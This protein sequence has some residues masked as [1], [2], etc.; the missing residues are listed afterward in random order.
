MIPVPCLG[1]NNELQIVDI[2]NLD[3]S[4]LL[5][6]YQLSHPIGL[7]K[8]GN[9]LFICDDRDGLKI[10]DAADVS[11]LKLLSQLKDQEVYDVIAQNGHAIVLG[12]KRFVSI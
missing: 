11:N 7:S 5:Q 2:H 10:Y 12:K 9:L 3:S 4:F 6:S 1:F 8:D